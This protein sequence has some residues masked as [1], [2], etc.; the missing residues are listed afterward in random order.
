MSDIEERI[1][2]AIIRIT[3]GQCSM[4][5][6]AEETDPDL[7]LADC[8]AEIKRLRAAKWQPVEVSDTDEDAYVID[9]LGHLLAEIAIVVNG[10]EPTGTR[11]SYHDLPKKVQDRLFSKNIEWQ[12]IETAPKDGTT[13]LLWDGIETTGYWKDYTFSPGCWQLALTGAYAQDADLDNPTH[14]APLP[15]APE[16]K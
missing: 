13:V 12:P 16:V 10:P 6:P 3:S 1:K 11:W 15:N 2:A 5:V 8:L 4:R 14:W 9:R 7:V